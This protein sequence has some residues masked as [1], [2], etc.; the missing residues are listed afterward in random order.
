MKAWQLNTRG[1]TLN[2]NR[3]SGVGNN[4]GQRWSQNV[5]VHFKD[6][7][8]NLIND[9]YVEKLLKKVI[10]LKLHLLIQTRIDLDLQT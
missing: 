8:S 2:Q 7:H 6:C 3:K 10:K 1:S 9:T 5:S 4:Q